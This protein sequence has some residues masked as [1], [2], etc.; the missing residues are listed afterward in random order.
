MKVI[1]LTGNIAAGKSTASRY[2]AAHGVKIIDA[3]TIAREVVQPGEPAWQALYETFGESYFL[4]SGELNRRKL[5]HLVFSQPE[6]KKKLDA[7]THRAI[8]A[9]ISQEIAQAQE[10][11]VVVDAALLIESGMSCMVDEIWLVEAAEDVRLTRIMA[12]DGLT[13]E[14]A[15]ARIASQMPQE[16]KV[17]YA[18]RRF[19]NSTTRDAFLRQVSQALMQCQNQIEADKQINKKEQT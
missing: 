13:R 17:R 5:G 11:I 14:A 16:E 15:A 8:V 3:D 19:D 7:I 18:K 4:E 12:R 6:E 2:L 1:G 10:D 9:R